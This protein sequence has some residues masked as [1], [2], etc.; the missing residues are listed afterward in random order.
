MRVFSSF[1]PSSVVVVRGVCMSGGMF[2][3]GWVFLKHL[4]TQFHLL[5]HL[6]NNTYY[7]QSSMISRQ[8]IRSQHYSLLL[9]LNDDRNIWF[10]CEYDAEANEK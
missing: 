6:D 2:V 5:D 9:C 4:V 7:S 3:T 10:L 1:Y 8:F